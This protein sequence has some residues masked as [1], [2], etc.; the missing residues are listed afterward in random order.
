MKEKSQKIMNKPTSSGLKTEYQNGIKLT[1]FEN[2]P[3][4][5]N[6]C[7]FDIEFW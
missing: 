7:I 1:I 6:I 4:L 3:D 2:I 5:P